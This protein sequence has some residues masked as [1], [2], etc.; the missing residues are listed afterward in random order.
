[1]ITGITVWVITAQLR[2]GEI[3]VSSLG[4]LHSM[5]FGNV[6]V[7]LVSGVIA[8]GHGLISNQEFDFNSLKDKFR[9]FDFDD[10]KVEAD[11]K[12][13]KQKVV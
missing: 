2:Y 3:S 10:E 9:S 7:F 11:R 4:E 13:I 5:L 12:V 8:I 1:M 6:T